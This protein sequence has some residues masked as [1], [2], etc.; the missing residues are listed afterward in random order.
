MIKLSIYT[1]LK[2]G[3]LNPEAKAIMD[4]LNRMGYN[5]L[6]HIEMGKTLKLDID[7]DDDKKAIRLA[8]KMCQNLLANPV[9]EDYTISL[10]D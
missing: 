9:M 5:Q 10:I 3:V 6:S 1:T 7:T 4:T 2:S 8:H